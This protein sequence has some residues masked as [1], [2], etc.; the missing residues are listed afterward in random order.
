MAEKKKNMAYSYIEVGEK[1]IKY[2]EVDLSSG[3][4][5]FFLPLA[6]IDAYERRMMDNIGRN[7]SRYIENHPDSALWEKT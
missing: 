6:E 7:M 3:E 5:T 1:V 4:V 2:A